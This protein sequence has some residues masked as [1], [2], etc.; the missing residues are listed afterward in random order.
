M[1]NDWKPK[2]LRGMPLEEYF[3]NGHLACAGCGPA[4]IMRLI[5]KA[6]GPNTIIVNAS[7]CMEVVSSKYP[8]TLNR[9]SSCPHDVQRVAGW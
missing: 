4:I 6:A 2:N 9:I 3:V 1:K 7:G 5:T 8:T